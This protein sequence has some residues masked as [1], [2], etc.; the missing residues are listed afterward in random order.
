MES[1][2]LQG[3]TPTLVLAALTTT[4][5]SYVSPV[6]EVSVVFGALLGT[7]VLREPFARAKIVGAALIFAGIVCIGLAA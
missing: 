7:L 3:N 5:V 2:L 6:R 4:Q 1:D